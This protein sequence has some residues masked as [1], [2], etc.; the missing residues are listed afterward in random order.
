MLNLKGLL[1]LDNLV[2]KVRQALGDL[3]EEEGVELVRPVPDGLEVNGFPLPL[4]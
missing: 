4:F 2:A 1:G 3:G